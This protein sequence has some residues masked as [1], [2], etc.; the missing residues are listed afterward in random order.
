MKLFI[1]DVPLLALLGFLIARVHAK[2]LVDR[3]PDFYFFAGELVIAAFWIDV[4]V[5]AFG[6]A[7]PWGC[8][9]MVRPVS[10]W[11]SMFYVLSYPLW[12]L[13]GGKRAFDLFGRNPRQ[14]GFLWPLRLEDRTKPFLAP[15]KQAG[16]E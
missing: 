2:F 7:N 3:H 12:F 4:L 15:W 13:W 14:G 16:K 10:R 1:L 11:I 8:A 5:C 9:C 6:H